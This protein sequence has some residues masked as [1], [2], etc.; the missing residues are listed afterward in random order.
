MRSVVLKEGK[1][2]ALAGGHPWIF[3]GA[4]ASRGLLKEDHRHVGGEV[5]KV[6]SSRGTFLAQAFF[7]PKRSGIVGRVI[8]HEEG[9]EPLVAVEHSIDRALQLRRT[10][11]GQHDP[12]KCAPTNAYRLLN[13]EG[14]FLPGLIV[15]KYGDALVMQ[16]GTLGMQRMKSE[17]VRLL[18]D[19]L[20]PH[21]I[22]EKSVGPARREEGLKDECGWLHGGTHTDH[23]GKESVLEEV[24]ALENGIRYIVPIVHGQKTGPSVSCGCGTTKC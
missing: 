22:Y 12:E 1:E 21:H 24:E 13:A 5:V 23:Q 19:K 10:A 20:R 18:L 11:F 6:F 3:S 2:A 15:D 4:V 7:N 16:V 8:S 9:V 17:L 14:D